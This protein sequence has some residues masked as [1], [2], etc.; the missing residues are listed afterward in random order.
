MR[1]WMAL[2]RSMAR[3][4]PVGLARE[5]VGAVRGADGDGQRVELGA[6]DE[7]GGLVGIGEQHFA[8]H[9]PVR[10]VAIL[11]VAHHGFQR[12]EAAELAFD[13]HADGMR[14]VHHPGA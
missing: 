7:I 10:A 14:H 9:L 4:S 2:I 12:P 8:R 6:P 11:L 1:L 13:G 5:L 3:M